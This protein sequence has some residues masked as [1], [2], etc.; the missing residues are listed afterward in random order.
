MNKI[1]RSFYTDNY[2]IVDLLDICEE[3]CSELIKACSK[4]KRSMGF[5]LSTKTSQEEARAKIVEEISHVIGAIETIK[6]GLDIGED[7]IYEESIK[8]IKKAK[9]SLEEARKA[10]STNG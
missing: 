9:A 1:D 2:P 8:A 6:I 3:E 5:G 7:E 4:M 10:E